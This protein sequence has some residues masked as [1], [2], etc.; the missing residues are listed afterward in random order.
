[1][2]LRFLGSR[3]F[4]HGTALVR[5]AYKR[6]YNSV[7]IAEKVVPKDTGVR[8]QQAVVRSF[9]L[10]NVGVQVGLHARKLFVDSVLNRVTNS[11]AAELRKK[12]AR[13]CVLYIY[14]LYIMFI[15]IMSF[16][17]CYLAILDHS[18][19]SLE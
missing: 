11:L 3:L 4:R 6:E 17:E 5:A 12:A 13:R 18:L 10:R 14:K 19:H 7:K 16:L 1:M 15:I 9:A 2:S 8:P